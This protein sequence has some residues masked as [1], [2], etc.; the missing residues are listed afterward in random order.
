M[1]LKWSTLPLNS[2]KYCCLIQ[3]KLSSPH[4]HWN[5][6]VQFCQFTIAFQNAGHQPKRKSAAIDDCNRAHFL[7]KNKQKKRPSWDYM[8]LEP[9]MNSSVKHA[10]CSACMCS[11]RPAFGTKQLRVY[12]KKLKKKSSWC[13]KALFSCLLFVQIIRKSNIC[14][15]LKMAECSESWHIL[16]KIVQFH[17]KI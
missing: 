16:P 7:H 13:R 3:S 14:A 10:F 1:H 4:I 5:Q 15:W 6:C 17:A 8:V 9:A 12:A 11:M 2:P